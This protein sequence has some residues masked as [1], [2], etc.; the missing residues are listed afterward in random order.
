MTINILSKK[1]L[2]I[3]FIFISSYGIAQQ[4]FEG[5]AHYI[6][7]T[8]V[9]MSN[10]SRPDMSED[11]KKRMAERMKSMFEKTYVLDFNKTESIF[12]AEEKLA[13]PT[14]QGGNG[15]PGG[16][17]GS[18]ISGA[19]DGDKYKNT[20][21]K[22]LLI[23]NELLGKKF[24][25]NDELPKLDWKTTGEVKQI[26]QY[27]CFKATAV[28]TWTDFDISNFRRPPGKEEEPKEEK[29]EEK[30]IETLV[31]AWYTLQIPVSQG[32]GN[33]WGLPGLILEIHEDNTIILCSKIVLNAKDKT[34][35]KK[36]TKGKKVTLKEYN[37]IATEKFQEMRENFRS[38]RGGDNNRGGRR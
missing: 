9:D 1:A 10:F 21:T 36:P 8:D 37:E 31:T 15:G 29:K 5:T 25:V 32:P 18:V 11:Q 27:M 30:Q 34:S 2:N 3:L 4:K 13:A 7:K 33:Y 24:L 28:K 6:S 12:K 38:R 35:I 17:F 16:R 26:G 14:Q 22:E 23:S 20:E 19:V